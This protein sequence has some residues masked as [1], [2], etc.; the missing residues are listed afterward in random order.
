MKSRSFIPFLHF[1]F[2]FM[3]VIVTGSC[4]DVM[5]VLNANFPRNFSVKPEAERKI[6]DI[7]FGGSYRS[8]LILLITAVSKL[9]NGDFHRNTARFYRPNF[10]V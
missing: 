9:E 1:H 10:R 3:F 7:V 4:G 8:I 5:F 2:R 6:S